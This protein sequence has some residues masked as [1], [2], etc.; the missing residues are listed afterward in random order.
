MRRAKL[1]VEETASGAE[2]FVKLTASNGETL[3]VGE[4]HSS[5]LLGARSRQAWVQ[6][7]VEV[8]EADGYTVIPPTPKEGP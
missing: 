3:G 2:V 5:G 1:Q 6:A 7:M 4:T 8:L